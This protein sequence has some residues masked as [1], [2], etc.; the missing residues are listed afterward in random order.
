MIVHKRTQVLITVE[1][2]EEQSY[3]LRSALSKMSKTVM[4]LLEKETFSKEEAEVIDDL[5]QSLLNL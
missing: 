3:D 2:T 5:R 1:M 4:L